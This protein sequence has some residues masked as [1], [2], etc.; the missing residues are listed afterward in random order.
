MDKMILRITQAFKEKAI[1]QYQK[2]KTKSWFDTKSPFIIAINTGDLD[3]P[4]DYLGIPLV[5]RAL[6]GLHYLEISRSGDKNFSWRNE[7]QK[8]D[9][10]PVNYFTHDSYNF[11][12]GVVFCDRMVV[13]RPEHI[14]DDCIF[15]NNPFASYP[16]NKSFTK[17]FKCWEAITKENQIS[18]TKLY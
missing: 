11:V 3:Y 16:V 1:D 8:G 12:S 9:G 14:G 6:F 15:V 4:Q 17:L 10:V 5:I 2:W 18:I 7:I 13:S